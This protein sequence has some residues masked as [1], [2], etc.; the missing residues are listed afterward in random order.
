M[1]P[2]A[3]FG[4]EDPF[5]GRVLDGVY[6]LERLLA[7]GGMGAV[8]EAQHLRL[9][10]RVAVKILHSPFGADPALEAR[11]EREVNIVKQLNHPHIVRIEDA[12]RSDDGLRF[13]VMEYLVGETLG[14]RLRRDGVLPMAEAIRIASDV[15]ATLSQVHARGFVHCD[16]KPANIFLQRVDGEPDFVKLLDFGVSIELQQQGASSLETVV[17][18]TPNYMA[19]E[20][21]RGDRDLDPRVDQFAVAAITYE[22]LTGRKA[23][24][25]EDSDGSGVQPCHVTPLSELAPWLPAA[26][27]AVLARALA[28]D[29]SSRYPSIGHFSEALAHAAANAGIGAERG[30]ASLAP[31]SGRYH[32]ASPREEQI[33][34]V[35]GRPSGPPTLVDG[36]R[37]RQPSGGEQRDPLVRVQE[38]IGA[39]RASYS[40]GMCY[41]AAEYAEELLDIALSGATPPTLRAIVTGMPL[42]DRVFAALVGPLDGLLARAEPAGA[43]P[44]PMSPR[45]SSVF[46]LLERP[47]TVAEVLE[48]SLVPTRDCI[49][50]LAGLLRSRILVRVSS[51]TP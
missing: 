39:M 23:L 50:V 14:K 3:D 31:A 25:R 26:F 4:S 42:I 18:G 20:Q 9:G 2:L 43:A 37:G 41:Q 24:L 51:R 1:L 16:M 19:P 48:T 5:L 17:A 21:A 7:R 47:M 33:D 22:M 32:V 45:A 15:C 11:F 13:F 46:A 35:S 36:P 27:D 10:S 34:G 28:T 12:D 44:R 8:Y 29:R 40:A 6:R 30:A 38:L 49:R